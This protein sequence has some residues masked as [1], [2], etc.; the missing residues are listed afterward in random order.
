MQW[1]QKKLKIPFLPLR[2]L[3]SSKGVRNASTYYI[4]V[5]CLNCVRDRGSLKI[6]GGLP[7]EGGASSGP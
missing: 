4:T 2:G 7:E 5:I 6:E 3:Q 1:I